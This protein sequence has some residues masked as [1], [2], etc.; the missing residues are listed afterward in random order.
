MIL[1]IDIASI[2]MYFKTRLIILL[3]IITT[4]LVFTYNELSNCAQ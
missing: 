4:L 1:K 2:E 3:I